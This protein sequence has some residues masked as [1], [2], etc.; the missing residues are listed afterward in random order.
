MD[1][2]TLVVNSSAAAKGKE[3]RGG[4][5]AEA[6]RARS[7][8]L[9]RPLPRRATAEASRA[10]PRGLARP[11]PRRATTGASRAERPGGYG[12]SVLTVSCKEAM[13]I[14]KS[15]RF[16]GTG[17]SACGRYLIKFRNSSLIGFVHLQLLRSEHHRQE[18]Q[19]LER[20]H[21]RYAVLLRPCDM[22]WLDRST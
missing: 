21:G 17:N 19:K 4:A 6:S 11:L 10:K 18:W 3:R 8:G 7:R 20:L 5:T 1:D 16:S 12:F 2:I 15:S 14:V 9:A 13:Q 22:S